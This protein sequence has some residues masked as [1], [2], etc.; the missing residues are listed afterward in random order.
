MTPIQPTGQCVALPRH[1]IEFTLSE[2]KIVEARL[3]DVSAGG[4]TGLLA[5]LGVDISQTQPE[6]YYDEK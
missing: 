3:E 6:G 2:G 4:L 1:R 5:S